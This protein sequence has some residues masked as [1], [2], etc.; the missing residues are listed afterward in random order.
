MDGSENGMK[1]VRVAARIA[2]NNKA[3]LTIL[4]VVTVP[5]VFYTGESYSPIDRVE[6]D[7]RQKGE[8][9]MAEAST[10]AE[11][12]GVKAQTIL[13][14]PMESPV[15]G[16]AEYSD[17]NMI[18]LV[19]AGTRGLGSFKRLLLGSVA[20]GLVHYSHCSVLVVR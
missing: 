10:V 3:E 9:A 12:S 8:R 16:I 7:A 6:R 2:K 15:K 18:D 13:V 11:E 4:H 19:V 1:A 5:S 20:S 17:K 14:G